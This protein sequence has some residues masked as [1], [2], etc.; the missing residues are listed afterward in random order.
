ME[1]PVDGRL[2]FEVAP[3]LELT[4]PWR[5]YFLNRPQWVYEIIQI[6]LAFAYLLCRYVV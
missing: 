4:L 1:P 3:Y 2:G 5:R 6:E